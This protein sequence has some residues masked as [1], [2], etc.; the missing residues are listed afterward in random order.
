LNMII[1][2]IIF[3]NFWLQIYSIL[4]HYVLSKF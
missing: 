1:A 4:D 3:S 2:N